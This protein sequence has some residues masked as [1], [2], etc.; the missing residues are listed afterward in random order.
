M[1]IGSSVASALRLQRTDVPIEII[2]NFEGLRSTPLFYANYVKKVNHKGKKQTRVLLCTPEMV[3]CCHP[4]GDITRCIPYHD[5]AK[6]FHNP[7]T[8]EVAFVVPSQYDLLLNAPDS[9]YLV[10]IVQTIREFH[11]E[12]VSNVMDVVV[13]TH[14]QKVGDTTTPIQLKKPPGYKLCLFDPKGEAQAY[15]G[16]T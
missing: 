15:Q 10:H 12:K 7:E 14:P 3:Y 6:L 1:N 8:D 2:Q 4:N 9:H 13:V 5:V 11:V 16:K